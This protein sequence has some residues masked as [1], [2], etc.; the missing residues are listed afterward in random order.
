MNLNENLAIYAL[1]E[2]HKELSCS[3][4]C[5]DEV[6]D[7]LFEKVK[8]KIEEMTKHSKRCLTEVYVDMLSQGKK[9]KV[10]GLNYLYGKVPTIKLTGENGVED[11]FELDCISKGT[12]DQ[13]LPEKFID[14]VAEV[15]IV[16]YG[17]GES[18]PI[19]YIYANPQMNRLFAHLSNGHEVDY[20]LSILDINHI[21]GEFTGLPSI[22][23]KTEVNISLNSLRDIILQGDFSEQEKSNLWEKISSL[24][25]APDEP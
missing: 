8:T 24:V 15:A 14:S 5:P 13:Y 1:K 2:Y 25:T 9:L 17:V 11:R 6:A 19:E 18:V 3:G 16:S 7:D 20:S 22:P 10:R 21:V 12:F 4:A 23:E